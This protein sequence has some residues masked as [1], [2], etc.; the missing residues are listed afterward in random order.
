MKAKV[1]IWGV[2][3][4]LATAACG[5]KELVWADTVSFPSGQWRGDDK[6]SFSPDSAFVAGEM[7]GVS[8]VVS[9]RY[10]ADATVESFRMVV[11][12]ENPSVGLYRCDTVAVRLLPVKRR[13]ADRATVGIFETCDT[14][15]FVD[16]IE[17]G[18]SITLYPA[19]EAT[20]LDGLFSLT[21]ELSR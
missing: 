19:G 11:E 9:I 18:C 17:P 8:P 20:T 1:W 10:G 5:R 15:G 4:L 16:R 3:L 12:T 21:F 7:N 13:T 14:L 2:G 6:L